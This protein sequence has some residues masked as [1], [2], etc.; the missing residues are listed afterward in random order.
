MAVTGVSGAGKSTLVN[1]ILYSAFA[2]VSQ[3]N[4][5]VGEHKE[6]LGLDQIDKVVTIDQKPI[7]GHRE[8]TQ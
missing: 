5:K 3:F 6:I 4:K 8:A 2:K 7:G 1:D